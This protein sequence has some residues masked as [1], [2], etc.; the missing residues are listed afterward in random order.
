MPLVTVAEFEQFGQVDITNDTDLAILQYLA[1]AE[2]VVATWCNRTFVY[3][4]GRVDVL[5]GRLAT[6]LLLPL[7]PV[8]QA[9]T[10]LAVTEN[11][12][13]LVEDDDY[14][15]YPE[16]GRL[17]RILGSYDGRT[18]AWTH[19][20]R[21]VV[22]TYDGGYTGVGPATP[23]DLKWVV[24]NVALRLYKAEA[25]WAA[26]PVGVG[27][28]ITAI[29]LEGVG[30]ASFAGG[31]ANTTAAQRASQQQGGS[32]PSLLPAEKQALGKYRRRTIAGA[33]RPQG[34]YQ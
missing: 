13:A 28:G 23:D 16:A 8:N 14:L 1:S 33:Y 3:E 10:P 11:G 4:S 26:T 34:V 7:Y 2:A 24:A 22:V 9:V 31:T 25:A 15:L 12:N 21:A 29:N 27:G 32:G 19:R 6:Q 5:D 20:R 18:T 30:N 17:I